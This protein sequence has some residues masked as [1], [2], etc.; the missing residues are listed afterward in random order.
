[1]RHDTFY[2]R[3]NFSFEFYAQVCHKGHAPHAHKRLIIFTCTTIYT[4]IQYIHYIYSLTVCLRS[5]RSAK[6]KLTNRKLINI[7][8]DTKQSSVCVCVWQT[9]NTC[10]S[11][12]CN[13][14]WVASTPHLL[15]GTMINRH[16]HFHPKV[17]P[18]KSHNFS[19]GLKCALSINHGISSS[20]TVASQ[21]PRPL[22]LL[23][24]PLLSYIRGRQPTSY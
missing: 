24:L 11:C 10:A 7:D 12:S 2:N 15:G 14:V 23:M 13:C 21:Q 1:M 4:Y 8:G 22:L 17:T 6:R 5:V 20:S 9:T 3:I 18:K 16:V 19:I